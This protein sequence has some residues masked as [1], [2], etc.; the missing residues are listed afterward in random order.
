VSGPTTA[1]RNSALALAG[2][3][4]IWDTPP[5]MNKVIRRTGIL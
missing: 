4:S 1:I 2:S 3:P 5:K